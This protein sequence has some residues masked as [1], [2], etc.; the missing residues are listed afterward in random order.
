MTDTLCRITV[1][2]A[3]FSGSTAGELT[4]TGHIVSCEPAER[5]KREILRPVAPDEPNHLPVR[6]GKEKQ[7]WH[8]SE[9]A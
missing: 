9:N 2:D 6:R 8:H 3:T 4:V 5:A 7:T 1:K